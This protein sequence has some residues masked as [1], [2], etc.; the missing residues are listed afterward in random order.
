M[1][2]CEVRK[3]VPI[4]AIVAMEEGK[5]SKEQSSRDKT[6]GEDRSGKTEGEDRSGKKENPKVKINNPLP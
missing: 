1:K 3:G 6:E 2:E 5:S 4:D